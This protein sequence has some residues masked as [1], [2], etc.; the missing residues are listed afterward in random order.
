MYIWEMINRASVKGTLFY[1][2]NLQG[3]KS[4]DKLLGSGFRWWNTF[5]CI[6]ITNEGLKLE[7]LLGRLLCVSFQLCAL[8]GLKWKSVSDRGQRSAVLGVCCLVPHFLWPL[9][10]GPDVVTFSLDNIRT[11]FKNHRRW[12]SSLKI[13]L[14]N[15][16]LTCHKLVFVTEIIFGDTQKIQ[17]KYPV[18][19]CGGNQGPANFWVSRHKHLIRTSLYTGH[20]TDLNWGRDAYMLTMKTSW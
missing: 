9:S 8:N 15:Y 3:I 20:G 11:H 7:C 16:M 6:T 19:F 14:L 2:V 17:L 4:G 13:V 12:H 18:G 10:T 5:M 1:D